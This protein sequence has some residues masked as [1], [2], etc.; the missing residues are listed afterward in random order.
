MQNGQLVLFHPVVYCDMIQ[1]YVLTSCNTCVSV[2]K[3]SGVG[4]LV[5]D[6]ETLRKLVPL[7]TKAH[8][9]SGNGSNG[10]SSSSSSPTNGHSTTSNGSAHQA[11]IPPLAPPRLPPCGLLLQPPPPFHI[12]LVDTISTLNA[13][14][15]SMHG[16]AC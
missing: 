6:L 5:Q 3:L 13:G 2:P 7:L 8:A 9:S 14:A 15:Q 11:S 1:D 10:H 12:A 16:S 4:L